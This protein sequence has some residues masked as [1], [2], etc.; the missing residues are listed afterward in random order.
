MSF[1]AFPPKLSK[2]WPV[3]R[4]D[5]DHWTLRPLFHGLHGRRAG[6]WRLAAI[7][8]AGLSA[9]LFKDGDREDGWRDL[10]SALGFVSAAWGNFM[11]AYA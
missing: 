5:G 9:L 6:S 7:G 1:W 2:S 10:R 8:H 3:R 11:L 4:W